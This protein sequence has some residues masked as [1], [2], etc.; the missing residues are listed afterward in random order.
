MLKLTILRFLGKW[1]EFN[2]YIE[3]NGH[4]LIIWDLLYFCYQCLNQG[5]SLYFHLF[6]CGW[7]S[8]ATKTWRYISSHSKH[9]RL[10]KKM[11]L[12]QNGAI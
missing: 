9:F 7:R 4:T 5:T 12:G 10:N 8:R 1:I 2:G 3:G 11:S 6:I